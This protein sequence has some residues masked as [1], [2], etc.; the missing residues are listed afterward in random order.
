MSDKT[1]ASVPDASSS[2]STPNQVKG[3]AAGIVAPRAL[4][5]ASARL[6]GDRLNISK[7]IIPY[8]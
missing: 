1:P 2:T 7:L 8:F 3:Q 6:I 5:A 4:L